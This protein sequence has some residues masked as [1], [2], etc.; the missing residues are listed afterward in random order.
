M[1]LTSEG[2]LLTDQ[3]RR[4]QVRLAITADSQA[5]RVW[6][7]T[8]DPNNLRRTQP[9]WRNAILQ[10]LEL[11][12]NVSARTAAQYLPRFREAETG[13]GSFRTAVPRFNRSKAVRELD[14]TGAVN[15]LWHIAKGDTQEAAW[16]AA[17]ELFLNTF[18]EAV[19]T[20]GRTTVEQ[21]AKQDPKAIGWRRV[22]DGNPCAFCAMLVSRGPVYTSA[23]KA[24]LSSKTGKKYHP[25]CGCTVE[26]VYG[27]WKPTKQEREW[28]DQYYRAAESLPKG[29]P[30]TP[31]TVLPIM[32]AGNNF[33]DSRTVRSTPE[34]LA[35][36]RKQYAEHKARE[37]AERKRILER[38]IDHP[39]R[40][41]SISKADQS[42][43]NPNFKTGGWAYTHNCQSCVPA[44]EMR[45]RG[46][47]VKARPFGSDE[48]K[49]T[50]KDT[51]LAWVDPATGR[52]PLRTHVGRN[53]LDDT[54]AAINLRV[55][56][57][58]RFAMQ[59]AWTAGRNGHIVVLER[60]WKSRSIIVVDPQAGTR[61]TL[62]RYLK[63]KPVRH[64]SVGIY[65]IDT[66]DIN[67]A[68]A[69]GLMEGTDQ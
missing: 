13:D 48:A 1:A 60:T 4:R 26:I 22:S 61:M 66:L 33:R 57:G 11:W 24:G 12:W 17:R 59:F 8:L 52:P 42:H 35:K 69:P 28:I 62:D 53:T 54:I 32:R 7:D 46:V 45:R 44:Y 19:L 49:R 3:H 30:R 34:Y 10:L 65:R 21:W 63:S 40:E 29:T 23:D 67:R 51:T 58:Q 16:A 55:Q 14:W 50:M 41:M 27:D 6:D 5:R 2:A 56:P 43:A 18:H 36:R 37:K 64:E 15:V 47:T 9:I 68:I 31:Q 39:G 20:G 38:M 25:K